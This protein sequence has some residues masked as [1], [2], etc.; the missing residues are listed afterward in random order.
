MYIS[1]LNGGRTVPWHSGQS[2]HA[3]PALRPATRLP[4]TNRRNRRKRVIFA[5]MNCSFYGTT[6]LVNVSVIVM[7]MRRPSRLRGK[8]ANTHVI[9]SSNLRCMK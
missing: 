9:E 1:H 4:Q 7:A 3:S 8:S 6:T 2:G 5:I